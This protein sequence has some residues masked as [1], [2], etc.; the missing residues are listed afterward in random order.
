MQHHFV[1]P[2]PAAGIPAG[3]PIMQQNPFTINR[4]SEQLFLQALQQMIQNN[5][6]MTQA[7]LA[8]G[9]NGLGAAGVGG[10]LDAGG[11]G[12]NNG[13]QQL[14]QLY[15]GLNGGGFGGNN[16]GYQQ[17]MQLYS[18]LNGGGGGGGQEFLHAFM[19]AGGFG[20]GGGLD[21]IQSLSGGGGGLDFLGG[22][23][24]GLGF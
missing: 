20:G 22:M 18:G 11:F 10:G 4:Q 19:N 16:N 23:L 17:L 3:F 24:G 2:Q 6:A 7:I 12:G 1:P 9:A 21:I 5:Q 15:S 8:G 14:M 13:Y